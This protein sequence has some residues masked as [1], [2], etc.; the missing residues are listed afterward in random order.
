MT[1]PK[2]PKG[3]DWKCL[4]KNHLG[5]MWVK[6][7]LT[8]LCAVELVGGG[9]G[10]P[11]RWQHHVSASWRPILSPARTCTDQEM[12]EVRAAFDMGGAEEDNHG[13]GIVR[14]LWLT[15]GQD[16]EPECPCK[17]DEVRTV[18][19]DRVRHDPA[20]TETSR[21]VLISSATRIGKSEQVES[22]EI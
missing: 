16:R 20:S 3:K 1:P 19:G 7:P 11:S 4:G 2:D 9:P 18:E 14:H 8:C 6:G 5:T 10:D 13:P 12:E 15:V 22:L 17:Q 21:D